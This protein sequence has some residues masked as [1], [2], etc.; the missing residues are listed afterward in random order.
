M[1]RVICLTHGYFKDARTEILFDERPVPS[2]NHPAGPDGRRPKVFL[3]VAEDVPDEVVAEFYRNHTSFLCEGYD[4]PAA[5]PV[6]AQGASAPGTDTAPPEGGEANPLAG[7]NFSSDAAAEHA[8]HLG[9]TASAFEAIEPSGKEGSFTK[10]DVARAAA[11]VGA[12][13]A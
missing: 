11:P 2:P 8:A 10:A 9:L 1:K 12:Q 3:G 5:A 7:V 6:G 4:A 13:G